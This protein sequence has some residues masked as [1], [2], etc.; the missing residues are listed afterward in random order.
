MADTETQ[1]DIANYR[2]NRPRAGSFK[3]WEM[4]GKAYWYKKLEL[5][6]LGTGINY[7]FIL[8]HGSV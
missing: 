8:F 4:L 3:K 1:T 6:A 2:L 5:F 7:I